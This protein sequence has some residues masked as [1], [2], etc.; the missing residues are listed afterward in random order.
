MSDINATRLPIYD[1]LYLYRT[2]VTSMAPSLVARGEPNIY[3]MMS[4]LLIH[5]VLAFAEIPASGP[6]IRS[7]YTKVLPFHFLKS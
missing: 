6:L 7:S 3:P 4:I 5:R 2:L 1:V